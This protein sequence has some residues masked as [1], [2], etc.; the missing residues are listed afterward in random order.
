MEHLEDPRILPCSHYYCNE[1]I[2]MLA[3]QAGSKRPFSCPECRTDIRLPNND[4]SRLPKALSVNRMKDLYA[5][6][7]AQSQA[8]P[9]SARVVTHAIPAENPD[10]ESHKMCAK[11]NDPLRLFCFDCN[12]LICRDCTVFDHKTHT[13][14]FVSKASAECR[15]LLVKKMA[16]LAAARQRYAVAT[17]RTKSIISEVESQNAENTRA[18][19]QW[20]E[21]YLKVI[22]S[23]GTLL[24]DKVS[25]SSERKTKKLTAQ[26]K[27]F[28][29]A[30]A[31]VEKV[32]DFC[33]RAI[34]NATD[35][36]FNKQI[37]RHVDGECHKHKT[38]NFELSEVSDLRVKLPSKELLSNLCRR[39]AC[40]FALKINTEFS[41]IVSV[42]CLQLN[43]SSLLTVRILL[44]NSTLCK[45][46][47]LV[48]GEVKSLVNGSLNR[49]SVKQKKSGEYEMVFTPQIRGR[50][51]LTVTVNG[52]L[53]PGSHFKMC[54]KV[55]PTKLGRQ[56][57][58]ISDLNRARGVAF[59]SSDELLVT[60]PREILVV[61]RQGTKLRTLKRNF[62]YPHGIGVDKTDNV[63]VADCDGNRIHKLDKF[64]NQL[65][66]TGRCGSQ[67]GE[68]NHPRGL[69]VNNDR[70]FVCDS[71]NHR[72]QVFTRDLVFVKSIGSSGT[73]NG[74]FR[75]VYDVSQ[76]E[77]G[78][79]YACDYNNHRIQVFNGEGRF[80]FKF[81]TEGKGSGQLNRP[82]GVCVSDGFVY[83]SEYGNVRVSVF[84]RKGRFVHLFDTGGGWFSYLSAVRVD[85]DGFLYICDYNKN[86]VQIF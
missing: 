50:H 70:V 77:D 20:V 83:V 11:H 4:P 10:L 29:G 56:D 58:A 22:Q 12:C 36:D 52:E 66:V 42:D 46:P 79:L 25:S 26:L 81:G 67:N 24:V 31:S 44:R 45:H 63:F 80:L 6:L 60:V 61:N 18:I 55:S 19:N 33:Q 78:N 38:T 72:I 16:P 14:K 64:G 9:S 82:A 5:K 71:A 74:Q 57:R 86:T 27:E 2:A 49:I 51:Q 85:K 40:V 59:N 15:D 73:G 68:F 48:Q 17:Q 65:K 41:C 76:D 75:Y 53:V 43:Q 39:E 84:D 28:E 34:E 69:V 32:R 47:Q 30:F 1:C 7:I 23:Y 3:Q 62:Q 13:Y 35:E 8:K 54:T 21:G 37:F